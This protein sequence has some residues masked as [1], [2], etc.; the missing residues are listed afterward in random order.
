MKEASVNRN[1]VCLIAFALLFSLEGGMTQGLPESYIV[2]TPVKG[3]PVAPYTY[4]SPDFQYTTAMNTK[5]VTGPQYGFL[6]SRKNDSTSFAGFNF[7]TENYGGVG[8]HNNLLD[9]LRYSEPIGAK[10]EI[11]AHIRLVDN[12]IQNNQIIWTDRLY[13]RG[14]YFM[15]GY[16]SLSNMF[17]VFVKDAQLKFQHNAKWIELTGSGPADRGWVNFPVATLYYS[18]PQTQTLQPFPVSVFQSRRFIPITIEYVKTEYTY[19]QRGKIGVEISIAGHKVY[20]GNDSNNTRAVFEFDGKWWEINS[21]YVYFPG[22][23]YLHP[24]AGQLISGSSPRNEDEFLQ[25]FYN[26]GETLPGFADPDATHGFDWEG[27]QGAVEV[28]DFYYGYPS[29]GRFTPRYVPTRDSTLK[30]EVV[31]PR[32]ANILYAPP[33]SGSNVTVAT[34]TTISSGSSISTTTGGGVSVSTGF[35]VD[36]EALS[37]YCGVEASIQAGFRS[38]WGST[39]S[40]EYSQKTTQEISVEGG[41][42]DYVMTDELTS[43]NTVVRRKRHPFIFDNSDVDSTYSTVFV[44]VPKSLSPVEALSVEDFLERH[45]DRQDVLEN[46]ANIYAKNPTTGEVKSTLP[47]LVAG[48]D[49]SITGGGPVQ[50]LEDGVTASNRRSQTFKANVGSSISG[51][52]SSG[53]VFVGGEV[54]FSYETSSE[55]SNSVTT[56]FVASYTLADPESWDIL[57]LKQ[58]LDT[59]N[60]VRI[61]APLSPQSFTSNPVEPFT[62]PAAQFTCVA[63]EGADSLHPRVASQCTLIVTNATAN[64]RA[65]GNLVPRILSLD[66]FNENDYEMSVIPDA[67][68]V[69]L[70]SGAKDTFHVTYT[71]KH[72]ATVPLKIK[73][74]YGYESGVNLFAHVGTDIISLTK[75]PKNEYEIVLSCSTATQLV[76]YSSKMVTASFPLLVRNIGASEIGVLL[77]VSD[78]S[79]GVTWQMDTVIASLAPD[80]DNE[81]DLVLTCTGG[82][83]PYTATAW[84]QGSVGGTATYRELTI[85]LDTIPTTAAIAGKRPFIK[86]LALEKV[87]SGQFRI[88]VPR[89][90]AKNAQLSVYAMDGSL[91]LSKILT[92]GYTVVDCNE[93][94][95]PQQF[96]IIKLQQGEMNIHR[97]IFTAAKWN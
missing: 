86:K 24:T 2:Y 79:P 92:P 66:V 46:F 4:K 82:R 37:G 32:I 68:T 25:S 39:T 80:A 69:I 15:G 88:A 12:N 53:S 27:L 78:Q 41:D 55:L 83:F 85:T 59:V 33:G 93:S 29:G 96:Y 45:K 51:K 30:E 54:Q 97:R 91:V 11:S 62:Q 90:A 61:F 71:P 52:I 67:K 8:I 7:N 35:E 70:D 36:P 13:M 21:H 3:E 81:I 49:I 31:F 19:E 22:V 1:R 14:N 40:F 75:V 56:E 74:E 26:R 34:S 42:G 38:E 77:G 84:I 18:D 60:G 20:F 65:T 89:S 58:Y 63:L 43:V 28:A 9:V 95:M 94:A 50:K 44:T 57:V 76:S 23:V 48:S 10:R 6:W 16:S 17:T 5:P 87:G 47:H 64:P 72:E 73:L